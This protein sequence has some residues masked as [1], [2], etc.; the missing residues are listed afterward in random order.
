MDEEPS[1]FDRT[2]ILLGVIAFA[3]AAALQWLPE[4]SDAR[5]SEQI[6]TPTA[7]AAIKELST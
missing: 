1:K 2:P 7:T 3:L 5:K 6:S 4:S